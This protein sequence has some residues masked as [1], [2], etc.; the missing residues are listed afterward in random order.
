MLIREK[1][2][3][4]YYC[5]SFR[6]IQQK[7]VHNSMTFIKINTT[8]TISTGLI[9]ITIGIVQKCRFVS[10]H[11]EK[12]QNS[13]IREE[14]YFHCRPKSL[15]RAKLKTLYC[16]IIFFTKIFSINKPRPTAIP[17]RC[18]IFVGF[19]LLAELK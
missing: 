5:D 19:R 8:T 18:V 6:S 11:R 10:I 2:F 17:W 16:S 4:K 13:I 7:F 1:R 14:K 9:D 15:R 12:L 3:Q